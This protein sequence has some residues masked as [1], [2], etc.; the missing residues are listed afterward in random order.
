MTKEEESFHT[1]K[2]KNEMMAKNLRN[3]QTFNDKLLYH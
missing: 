1:L 3:F 2:M